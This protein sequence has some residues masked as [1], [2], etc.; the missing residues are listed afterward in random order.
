MR[1]GEGVS[2]SLCPVREIGQREECAAKEKHWRYKEEDRQVEYFNGRNYGSEDHAGAG[3]GQ[4][5]DK[6]DRQKEK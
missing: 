3:K 2:D 1:Q 4:S 6:C 5:A